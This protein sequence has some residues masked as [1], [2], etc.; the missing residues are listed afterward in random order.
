MVQLPAYAVDGGMVPAAM[1][2][3]AT[4]ALSSGANG[5]VG[6]HDLKVT[7]L[8]TAG[9][10]VQISRGSALA[11]MRTTGAHGMETYVISQDS[12][13][14]LDVP[15]TGGSARTDFI[16]ARV[17]DW[18]FTGEEPPADP[19]T[20]LYWE[21]ARVST[22]SGITYPFVPLAR[23]AIPANRASI[24]GAMITDIR[25]VAIPRRERH[26]MTRRINSEDVDRL[27][28]IGGTGE[29]WPDVA[30][31]DLMVPEWA[32]HA[33]VVAMFAQVEVP[34]GI[35]FDGVVFWAL[36]TTDPAYIRTQDVRVTIDNTGG[37]KTRETLVAAGTVRIPENMRGRAWRSHTRGRRLSGT[38]I[39]FTSGSASVMDVEF[40]ERAD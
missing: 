12:T 14:N 1:A 30:H 37:S 28:T 22:L 6:I 18:H 3:R 8:P 34:A 27:T 11:A 21:F 15:P 26:V 38:P 19:T 7:A 9:A 4:H 23:I 17:M 20:A 33:N 40:V 31:V 10:G 36:G 13:F 39:E 25:E 5:V 2:R 24:T 35:E 29:S 16:I 32:T